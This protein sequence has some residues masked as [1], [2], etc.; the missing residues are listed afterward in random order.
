MGAQAAVVSDCASIVDPRERLRCYDTSAPRHADPASDQES[1]LDERLRQEKEFDQRKFLI[2][3]WRPNYLLHT[4]SRS[5]N[6]APYQQV[7]PDAKLQHQEVKYQVSLRMRIADDVFHNNGNVWFGYTQLSLW[8]VYNKQLSSPF[9][10]TNYEP[11][12]GLS[13]DTN[14]NVFG[15]RHRIFSIGFSHQS[16]GQSE[17]LSRSWNRLWA[18]FVL[19]RGNYVVAI[20]PWYRLPESAEDDDNPD[21]ADYAGRGEIRVIRKSEA[22]V[23][24]LTLRNNFRSDNNRGGAQLDWSFPVGKRVKGLVQYYNGY[25]ESLIDY[26]VYTHRLGIGLQISDWL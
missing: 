12:L 4:Y 8:Q 7:E 1:L 5:P 25:G 19:E 2:T 20:T 15:W 9:R 17:P 10:E 21:I 14:F 16:N 22:H 23:Y 18:N 6:E 3:L 26:N 24:T 11:E 13:I